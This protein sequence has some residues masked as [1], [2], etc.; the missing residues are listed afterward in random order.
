MCKKE[1]IDHEIFKSAFWN[2]LFLDHEITVGLGHYVR[3]S[4]CRHPVYANLAIILPNIFARN[5][6]C[7]NNKH[8]LKGFS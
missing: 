8:V 3:I 7:L 2:S 6:F 5:I 1:A 4:E